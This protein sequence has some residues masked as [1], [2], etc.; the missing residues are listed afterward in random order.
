MISPGNV[1]S[2]DSIS[3]LKMRISVARQ[4]STKEIAHIAIILYD[5]DTALKDKRVA[6]CRG[7]HPIALRIISHT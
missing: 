2:L 7:T 1:H 6:G 5:Q 4:D 3:R